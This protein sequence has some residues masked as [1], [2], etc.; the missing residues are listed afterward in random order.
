M[1]DGTPM[2]PAKACSGCCWW[3]EYDELMYKGP[4]SDGLGSMPGPELWRPRGVVPGYGD[5]CPR[6]QGRGFLETSDA[7]VE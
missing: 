7:G 6:T 1:G 4:G 2:V 5:R 3:F